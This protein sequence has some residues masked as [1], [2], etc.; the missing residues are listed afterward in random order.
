VTR[1]LIVEPAGNLW[2]SE[3]ALLGFVDQM[4]GVEVAVCCPPKSPLIPE[5]ERRS[6]QVFPFF[7]AGLHEK[8]RL[9]RLKAA[10]GVARACRQFRPN[11][12]HLNQGGC[13]Q[14]ALPAALLFNLPVIAHVRIYDDVAYLALRLPSPSRLRGIVAISESIAQQLRSQSA[15]SSIPQHM[16][17]DSYA[18]SQSPVQSHDAEGRRDR[19]ACVG[20]IAPI[21]GQDLLIEAIHR[22]TANGATIDCLLLGDGPPDFVESLK[23]AAAE[24]VGANCFQW[25]GTREDVLS[26][27]ATCAVLVCPSQKE[28]LG[29]IILEA[30]D[31]GAIPVAGRTSGG[32]A[33]IISAANGGLLYAEQTV[34]S[35]SH[36]I[37]EALQVPREKAAEWIGNGRSWISRHCDPV[38]Y[39]AAMAKILDEAAKL[40]RS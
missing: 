23:A 1:V 31:A 19:I 33:E 24:G 34:D 30:W 37:L 22:L 40:H 9:Q 11:V 32:A 21:K 38:A 2:G 14:V 27:L 3:R 15:L 18:I 36:T 12:I 20:R 6:I 16:L 17:Y 25:L 4:P 7:I 10:V 39:G 5:L 29:R 26:L 28:P 8:S 13:Y 35:L